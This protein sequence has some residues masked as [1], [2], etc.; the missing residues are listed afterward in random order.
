M[1]LMTLAEACRH[2]AGQPAGVRG[3][4]C[5]DLAAAALAGLAAP[6]LSVFHPLECLPADASRCADLGR[7]AAS[8]ERVCLVALDREVAC[9]RSGA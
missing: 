4:A 3:A 6:S 9:P 8:G 1:P 2:V 5:R 7:P